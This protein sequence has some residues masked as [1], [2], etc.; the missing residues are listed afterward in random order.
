MSTFA[1][2]PPHVELVAALRDPHPVRGWSLPTWELQV[3]LSRR[4]RLLSRL[5][6]AVDADGLLEDVPPEPR[7]HL[8]S[9]LHLSQWRT[10]SMRWAI[11]RVGAQLSGRGYPIV[12]LK[13][14]AYLAQGL[15]IARGRLPSDLDI[16][17]PSEA[18]GDALDR[19]QQDGWQEVE[20]DAH[21][22]RY[23]REWSHEAPPM[24]H[25]A[26]RMELDVHHNI[27]PPVGRPRVDAALLLQNLQHSSWAGWSVLAPVDQFLHGAAHLF[28]DSV[29][30]D[31]LR[32]LVDLDG[33]AR[34]FEST[35]SFWGGA[36]DRAKALGLD[37]QFALACHFL[38][39]WLS[40]PIPQDMRSHAR[41]TGVSSLRH[42]LEVALLSSALTPTL[43]D[44]D[45]GL[46]ERIIDGLLLGRYHLNR[47]PMRLLVPH[48]AH[49]WLAAR[50]ADAQGQR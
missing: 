41:L 3:R 37:R 22:Q 21:D 34:A 36:A 43:P 15:A 18:L 44:D 46:R 14:A 45:P 20:L 35:R 42:R 31:R 38:T 6:A 9:A 8:Q 50:N 30:R 10:R 4:L 23:Y 48:L 2:V 1:A 16:L 5:A 26:H 28:C 24:R 12:L 47:M 19:L 11:D 39:A 40:T 29:Q 33:L 7:R 13:G 17:V 32:D 49:K 27:L 25:P